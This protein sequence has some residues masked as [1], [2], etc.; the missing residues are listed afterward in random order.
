MPD[1]KGLQ[2]WERSAGI[3]DLMMKRNRRAYDCI[4]KLIRDEINKESTVLELAAGTGLIA[5]RVCTYCKSYIATDYSVKMLE[6]AQKKEWPASVTFSQADAT[7]L[8]YQDN[9][10]DVVII[11]NA[12]HIMPEPILAL[13]NIRRVLREDGKL[14]APT[15][16]RYGYWKEKFLDLPMQ[17]AGF[18]S[19]SNWTPQEYAE[20]LEEN[21]WRVIRSNVIHA[22]FDIAF[23]VAE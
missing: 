16:M 12:L 23:V 20:F 22:G 7:A 4:G 9:S 11:S 8:T 13:E 17:F 19:F 18:K 21:K 14:I 3:Y 10:F 15:F 6:K 5:Q 1:N 2:F